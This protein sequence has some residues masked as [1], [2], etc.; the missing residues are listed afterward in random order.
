MENN[1]PK[2]KTKYTATSN[3]RL[4]R[5]EIDK[6]TLTFSRNEI[7][8]DTKIIMIRRSPYLFL[9]VNRVMS[10]TSVFRIFM[11]DIIFL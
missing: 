7:S 5:N 1:I 9:S 6:F 10:I 8:S 3:K 2:T 4:S 11:A